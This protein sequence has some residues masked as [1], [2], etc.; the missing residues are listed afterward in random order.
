[1][2]EDNK[3][4]NDSMPFAEWL[5]E[6]SQRLARFRLYWLREHAADSD[7]FPSFMAA[8]DWDEAYQTFEG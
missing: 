2:K 7:K 3:K 1:M 8:S 4:T 5:S 6:E